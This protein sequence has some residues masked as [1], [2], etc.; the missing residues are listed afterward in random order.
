MTRL[1]GNQNFSVRIEFV[2]FFNQPNWNGPRSNFGVGNFG[3][4]TGQ[5]GYP[6]VLQIMFKYMF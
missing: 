3:R 2:N 6:R 1:G 4:I 5:G